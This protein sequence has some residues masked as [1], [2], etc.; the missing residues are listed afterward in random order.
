MDSIG[1]P[2]LVEVQVEEHVPQHA[3]LPGGHR[4]RLLD[5]VPDLR[6]LAALLADDVHK[7]V[8]HKMM[9]YGIR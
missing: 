8:L 6:Q 1:P 4:I 7:D 9:M 5:V 2:E 3:A